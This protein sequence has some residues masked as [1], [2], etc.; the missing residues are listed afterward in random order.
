MMS[1][2]I[3]QELLHTIPDLYATEEIS[4]PICH[5]K[6]FTPD[7]N[8]TWYVIEFS[9]EDSK[10]CFGF[11]QGMESELGYFSLDE[12]ELLRGSLGLP[13]ERDLSFKP[14]LLSKI[15]RG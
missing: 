7:S 15:K 4:D 3:P 5:I 13:I 14:T 11:V 8:W 10:M 6:L 2:L 1:I 12:L 9:K